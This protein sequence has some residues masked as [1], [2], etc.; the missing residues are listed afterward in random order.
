MTDYKQVLKSYFKDNS[1]VESQI[2]SY[3]YF[4]ENGLKDIILG[5]DRSKIPEYLL[6]VYDEVNLTIEDVWLGEPVHIE[7]DGSVTKLTPQIARLRGLTYAAPLYL[8][9][10]TLIGTQK[11]EFEVLQD[12]AAKELGVLHHQAHLL[13]HGIEGHVALSEAA[14]AD[15]PRLRGIETSDQFHQRAFAAA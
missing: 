7:V 14:V 13:A 9:V 10:A 12:R 8:K 1:L 3:N 15:H 2:R 4:I 11:D 6:D 5:F